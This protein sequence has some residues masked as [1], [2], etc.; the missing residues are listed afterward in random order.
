MKAM[1]L[2]KLGE[3]LKL[4][5]IEQPQPLDHQVLIRVLACG[6]CRTD[7]HIIDGEIPAPHLPL[8]LGHQIVGSLVAIGK[9]VTRFHL[10][11]RVGVPWL[12]HTCKRCHYC[13]SHHENLCDQA[14]FT[15]YHLQGGYA[16]YCV[17]DADYI[18]ALPQQYSDCDVA[19]LLCAGMIG[20]RSLKMT[21]SAQRI[22]FYGFGASAHL[23]C[24]LATHQ[25]K[26][27]FAFTRP[28]DKA[29][30]EFARSLGAVWVGSSLQRPAQ[31]L[32]A[33]II[34]APRGELIPLALAAV[35]KG[36][37]V[38]SAGIH[39]S[40]IPAFDYALLWG[41]RVLCSVAN[42]TR[43]DGEEFLSLASQFPIQ[44]QVTS[45]PLQAAN[46]AL[47]DLKQGHLHGSAVLVP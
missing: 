2:H 38:V 45:Y 15:G 7:L 23:L 11:Q 41:E 8:I 44:A 39:M 42:L 46:E 24:Q 31:Q 10:G 37:I 5:E 16:E 14:L 47:S 26:E 32:D 4:Q 1:L 36:G 18:F 12:G 21:K 20:Y 43:E 27:V 19:P 40:Q 6:V 34:F 29:G 28:G 25:G 33:A 30:Q 35:R 22:G 3:P 13:Y 9:N 17:A